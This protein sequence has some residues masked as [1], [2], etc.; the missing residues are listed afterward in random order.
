GELIPELADPGLGRRIWVPGLSKRR[1]LAKYILAP[2]AC[3]A[4]PDRDDHL[5]DI[6]RGPAE[7]AATQLALPEHPGD[8]ALRGSLHFDLP[9]HAMPWVAVDI[10]ML[11]IEADEV[12]ADVD[13]PSMVRQPDGTLGSRSRVNSNKGDG[14]SM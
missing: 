12:V 4:S 3:L 10:V 11:W 8:L 9:G 5:C 6:V 1:D 7:L 13:D 14:T 2:L